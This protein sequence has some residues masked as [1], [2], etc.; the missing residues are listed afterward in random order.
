MDSR[1]AWTVA[2]LIVSNYAEVIGPF[3]PVIVRWWIA[4]NLVPF[5]AGNDWREVSLKEKS[6][7][8]FTSIAAM[9]PRRPSLTLRLR[10]Y[11]MA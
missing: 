10:R 5:F 11:E 4:L 6:Y 2:A 1:G 9:F 7:E 3:T 8:Y